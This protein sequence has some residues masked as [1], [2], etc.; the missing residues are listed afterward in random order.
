MDIISNIAL[1]SINETL[2]V[3]LISFLIFL[4]IINRIMFRPINETI[5]ER[6][7]YIDKKKAVLVDAEKALKKLQRRIRESELT[8][9]KES[10]EYSRVIEESGTRQAGLIMADAREEIAVMK[11]ENEAKVK[12][13]LDDARQH[14]D[15]ESQ[16]L[17]Q[18]IMGRMLNRNI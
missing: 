18:A 4:F 5:Q 9:K 7:A 6:Y 15:K 17:A 12:A 10:F 8:V 13:L 16:V 14:L 11:K 2:L 1:I 3:Q